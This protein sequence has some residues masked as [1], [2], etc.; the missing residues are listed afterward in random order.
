MNRER[1]EKIV[2]RSKIMRWKTPAVPRRHTRIGERDVVQTLFGNYAGGGFENSP[3]R[4]LP[5]FS[6]RP[7]PLRFAL[8]RNTALI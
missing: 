8:V 5:P 4:L 2:L 3:G 7:A 6:V 1:R